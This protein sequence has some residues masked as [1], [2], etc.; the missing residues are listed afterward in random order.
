V[1]PY[2][3]SGSSP[4][5]GNNVDTRIEIFNMSNNPVELQ[6]FYVRQTKKDECTEVGFYITL[7]ANQPLSWFVD[8][9]PGLN[10]TNSRV[11][12]FSGVGE[13]K[14]AVS[15][16]LPALSAHNVVQGRAIVFDRVTGENIGYGA[17]GFQKLSPGGFT[18]VVDL[19]GF[20]Y[21]SCPDRLHFQVL[22][23]RSGGPSSGLITVTCAEDLWLQR[24]PQT[25]VQLAII[26]EFEQVFSSSFR[27]TCMSSLAFSSLSTLSYNV[28]GTDTAHVIVRGVSEPLIGMVIDRFKGP[29]MAGPL[30]TTANEP[31]LEGGR[32]S[33]VIFP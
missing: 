17:I 22:A 5:I 26:N 6:C 20:S 3:V 10:L 28:L 11:P 13:L 18:G 19:D 23:N 21:E 7:T 32:S 8:E 9:G 29:G 25:T 15:S 31:F 33:T 12:P 27:F 2:V 14:C 24:W 4:F 1:F 30:H 16:P